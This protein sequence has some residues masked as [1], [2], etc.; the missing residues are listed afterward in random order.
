[1][2]TAPNQPLTAKAKAAMWA[3]AAI[4]MKRT[5]CSFAEALRRVL[6]KEDTR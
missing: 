6:A 3:D 4:I 5:G 1:M 2:T